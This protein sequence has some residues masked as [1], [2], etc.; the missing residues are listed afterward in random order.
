MGIVDIFAI[1]SFHEFR[2]YFHL[3]SF[4]N[5]SY[6]PHRVFHMKPVH[7]L[8]DLHPS[9]SKWLWIVLYLR[10]LFL[11]VIVST[12]KCNRRVCQSCAWLFAEPTYGSQSYFLDVL[13]F[14]IQTMVSSAPRDS[15]S[16]F[17]NGMPFLSFSS[18]IG[19]AGPSCTTLKRLGD[20]W[21]LCLVLELSEKSSWFSLLSMILAVV[22]VFSF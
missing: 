15:V 12:Q 11:C 19:L 9:I 18:L 2:K 10:F 1:L 21:Y 5:F 8:L 13:G 20:G 7:V 17:L 14:S 6:Q 3:L 4:L 16:S 22:C